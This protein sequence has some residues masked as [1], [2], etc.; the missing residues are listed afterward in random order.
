MMWEQVELQDLRVFQTICQERHFGRAADRLQLSRS[1]VS[2]V[3]AQLEVKLGVRLFNRTSRS[4]TITADGERLHAQISQPY[5]ELLGALREVHTRG[6]RV[7]GELRLGLLFP[8]SGG[9]KL[10]EIV[11]R[12][13]WRH[14][15]AAVSIREIRFDDPIGPLLRGEIEM[16]ACFLPMGHPELSIGP[17]LASEPRILAVAIDHPL[18]ARTSV[19]LEDLAEHHTHDAGNKLPR[20]YLDVLIPPITPSGRRIRR[21]HLPTPSPSQVLATVAR[22]QIVHPT[23]S[24]FPDHFRH[25][26]VTF[27]PFSDLPPMTSGLVWHASRR[28]PP[29]RAFLAAASEVLQPT[30]ASV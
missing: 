25:P 1:R 17:T 5:G 12:F 3:L 4:V 21:L 16:M 18:A 2:Q 28:T 23:V 19:S 6:Q 30:G 8:S 14:P 29:V 22:G 27:V 10:E 11:E 24:S 20:D 7:G 9:V 13:E 15:A 26:R